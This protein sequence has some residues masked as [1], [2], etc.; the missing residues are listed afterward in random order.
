[1]QWDEK[2]VFKRV[3]QNQGFLLEA[4]A[5]VVDIVDPT[6]TATIQSLRDQSRF[7]MQYAQD[8]LP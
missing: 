2:E 1:M 4:M 8:L 7:I 6:R 3:L 5:Q